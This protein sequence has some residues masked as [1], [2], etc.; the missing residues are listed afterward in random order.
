MFSHKGPSARGNHEAQCLTLPGSPWLPACSWGCMTTTGI[1]WGLGSGAAH[2][3]LDLV[4]WFGHLCRNA[5]GAE[6]EGTQ[7]LESP[8]GF[9][10]DVFGQEN[11]PLCESKNKPNVKTPLVGRTGLTGLCPPLGKAIARPR[12]LSSRVSWK[13]VHRG[14]PQ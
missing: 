3:I 6:G 1:L 5:Q 14:P 4:L 7:E 2:H 12:K 11:G 10:S 9:Q 13:G 8:V